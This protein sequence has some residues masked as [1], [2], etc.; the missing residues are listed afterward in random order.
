MTINH[1]DT[2]LQA[3]AAP[4]NRRLGRHG[5]AGDVLDIRQR[6]RRVLE[7][8]RSAGLIGTTKDTRISARVSSKLRE[9]AKRRAGVTGDSE[10]IELALVKLALEDDFG[11]RLVALKG[12]LSS[13]IE[14]D[15]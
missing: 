12:T 13:D 8:A 3:T 14:F 5:M 9:A 7:E 6:N 1:T 11:A 4:L 2:E 15:F 10:L